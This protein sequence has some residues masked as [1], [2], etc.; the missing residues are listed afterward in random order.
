MKGQGGYVPPMYIPLSQSQS[1][2]EEEE[3]EDVVVAVAAAATATAADAAGG[4]DRDR[5][6]RERQSSRAA[7]G[8]DPTQWSSGI[9]ACFD[10]MQSCCIGAVCPCFLFGKNAEFLGSGTLAGSCMTHYILWGVVNCFCCLFTGGILSVMP[11]AMVA[12]YACGYRK[13]LRTKYK[14]QEAPCGDLT[15][16][17]FCHLCAICQE[18]REIRERSDGSVSVLKFPAITA[19]EAQTMELP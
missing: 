3:K 2:A 8:H 11:G 7:F 1:D 9:C 4:G 6:G 14:L 18:Y 5:G 12:C 15:T 17:L 10:D 16:H 19:P 13:A